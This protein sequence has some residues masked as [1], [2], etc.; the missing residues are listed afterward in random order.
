M[1]DYKCTESGSLIK[2]MR[3]HRGQTPFEC[4]TCGYKTGSKRAL[5]SHMRTHTGESLSHIVTR[6]IEGAVSTSTGHEDQKS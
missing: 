3:T 6:A 1:C 5:K 2:H 4:S